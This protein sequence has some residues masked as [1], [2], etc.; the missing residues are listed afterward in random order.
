MRPLARK[1]SGQLESPVICPQKFALISE[2]AQRTFIANYNQSY[3]SLAMNQRLNI[4][5][6]M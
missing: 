2:D 6:G 5:P 1:R 4:M 3:L